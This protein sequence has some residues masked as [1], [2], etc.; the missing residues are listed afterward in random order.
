MTDSG[1]VGQEGISARRRAALAEQR[2]L[3]AHQRA[4]E[5]HERAAEL[6]ERL[7]YP[8]RAANARQHAEQARQLLAEGREERPAATAERVAATF[9]LAAQVRARIA[10]HSGPGADHHRSLAAP[11]ALGPRRHGPAPA[12]HRPAVACSAVIEANHGGAARAW[13][14]WAPGLAR[15][16]ERR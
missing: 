16:P 1:E 8:D 14:R 15:A 5:L 6:K 9:T 11:L 2:E 10:A 7:G 3:A 12:P 4:I 13:Q